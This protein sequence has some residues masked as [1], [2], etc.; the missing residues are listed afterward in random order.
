MPAHVGSWGP[1]VITF[2]ERELGIVL[3]A[4]QRRAITRA[5]AV[6]SRQRLVHREYLVSTGR[7][8]GK[9]ALVRSLVG[10][11][12]T[13][14]TGPAW[15]LMYGLA[16]N[17]AQA[18]IP[19]DAVRKDL[20]PIA[21]RLGSEARGGLALTRYLGIRSAVAGWRREYHTTSREARDAL[22]GYSI[23]LAL[24]DEV[25]TQHDESVYAALKPTVAARPEPLIF[26]TSS[27]GDERSLLLRRL[28]ERGIRI[29]DGAEPA[30]GFGM[31]W[32]AAGDGDA[33]DDPA[34]WAKSSPA[35]LE[36]RLTEAAI[37]DELRSM[38]PSTFRRERLNLWA[39]ASD[40][41][42]PPGVWA[43]QAGKMPEDRRRVVLAIDAT[44][45]WE[46]ATIAVAVEPTS[47]DAP[48]FVGIAAD[49][50]AAPGSSVAPGELIE[51]LDRVASEWGPALAVWSRSS[52]VALALRGWATAADLP[53]LE[54][55][56]GDLRSACEIFRSELVGSRLVH[57]DD[58]LLSVQARRARPS[59]PLE[60]GGWYF[61]V[62]ESE[63][64]IDAIR[65]IAFASW[66][67]ISPDAEPAQGE[68]F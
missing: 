25:R 1:L 38:S 56:G 46:R 24:F 60:A 20:E 10:W 16:Y 26:E 30:E 57:A 14:D 11:A 63:G 55:T 53:T 59:G 8:C 50:S 7:Q 23:D 40:E 12:L 2:A 9:S 45:G 54:L 18:K 37:R 39:D 48:V 29:I 6:D 67:S 22:R 41:W 32:Y 33:P 3:D 15:S 36:G 61:S 31:T 17:R 52:S 19:Y 58:P 13:T 47:D 28:W 44:P 5:L 62:R 64:A 65:A 21:R 34:G 49:L 35:L 51:A 4:W 66:A 68:I 27:A 42:L 43:R